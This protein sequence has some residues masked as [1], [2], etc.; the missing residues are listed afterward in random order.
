MLELHLQGTE[1][2]P[3]GRERKMREVIS[4]RGIAD[5]REC[6]EYA[7]DA[8]DCTEA[9]DAL[10]DLHIARMYG[11]LPE[12]LQD[13]MDFVYFDASDAEIAHAF[14]S[15]RE[16][17]DAYADFCKLD[18]RASVSGRCGAYTVRVTD[19]DAGMIAELNADAGTREQA[20][21]DAHTHVSGQLSALYDLAFE[22]S[23]KCEESP[24]RERIAGEM[25][26][27]ATDALEAIE[28]YA[29]LYSVPLAQ[30]ID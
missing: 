23:Q 6:A 30:I 5:Y 17:F 22:T 11:T 12:T 10:A 4:V 25:I 20:I 15:I 14:R 9:N 28:V 16:H 18:T 3:H 13:T 2:P 1:C 21:R 26:E 7:H 27:R 24:V 8:L 29:G 19:T